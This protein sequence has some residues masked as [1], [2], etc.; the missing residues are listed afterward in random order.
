[1]IVPLARLLPVAMRDLFGAAGPR[2]A[3]IQSDF[4]TDLLKVNRRAM[5]AGP[6]A[7]LLGRVR[8]RRP[9]RRIAQPAGPHP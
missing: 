8:D 2:T 5:A 7:Y 6:F 4:P 9:T 3:G 1:M